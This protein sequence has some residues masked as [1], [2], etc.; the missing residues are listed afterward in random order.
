[1]ARQQ[2]QS[3]KTGA[4]KTTGPKS[5]LET[6]M[7]DDDNSDD[8][9]APPVFD[10]E[11]TKAPEEP[12]VAVQPGGA[13]DLSDIDWIR[14]DWIKCE[15]GAP[16]F[17]PF[18]QQQLE[19]VRLQA[20]LRNSKACLGTCDTVMHWHSRPNGD[21]HM[22][23]MASSRHFLSR[24]DLHHFLKERHD[25]DTV[26]GIVNELVLSSRKSC[27]RM[28]TNDT[29]K[30]MQSLLARPENKGKDYLV[31]D[32]DPFKPPPKDLDRIANGST[33]R[34]HSETCDAPIAN[35]S[36][37]VLLQVQ[38]AC[39]GTHLGQFSSFE[40]TSVQIALGLLTRQARENRTATGE[41]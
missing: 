1:L 17:L 11:D 32:H 7:E 10:D 19:A 4:A 31:H 5:S 33:G 14:N 28:V 40:L 41:P 16:N 8:D 2:P 25:R 9:F 29:A 35:P 18:T 3:D 13:S 22:H 6:S 37:Q 26:C 39:D 30:I 27:V 20:I 34:H 38:G 15:K 21:V 23:K 12:A 36:T 24:H